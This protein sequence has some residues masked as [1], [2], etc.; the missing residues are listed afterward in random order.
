MTRPAIK[1]IYFLDMATEGDA[2]GCMDYVLVGDEEYC[3]SDVPGEPYQSNAE[4]L[5]VVF[6]SDSEQTEKGFQAVLSVAQPDTEY[7]YN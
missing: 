2:D 3:G 6:K 7:Y 5:V 4:S 1:K